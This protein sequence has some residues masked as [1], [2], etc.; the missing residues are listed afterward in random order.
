MASGDLFT[1][2]CSSDTSG[3]L[4]SFG[5]LAGLHR[6]AGTTRTTGS[7]PSAQTLHKAAYNGPRQSATDCT[8]LLNMRLEDVE[9]CY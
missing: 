3:F 9:D 4:C 1:E 5:E 7:T 6:R 2:H 8:L